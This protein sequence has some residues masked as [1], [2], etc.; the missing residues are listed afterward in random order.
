[1]S[2]YLGLHLALQDHGGCLDAFL[3]VQHLVF[4][5]KGS[6]IVTVGQ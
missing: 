3:Q 5:A 4:C 1:M 6:S 2:W